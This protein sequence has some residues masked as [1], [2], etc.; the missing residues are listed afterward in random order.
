[1]AFMPDESDGHGDGEGNM[2]HVDTELSLME[3]NLLTRGGLKA[4]RRGFKT[5]LMTYAI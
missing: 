1:M 3:N 5:S 2:E 4:A